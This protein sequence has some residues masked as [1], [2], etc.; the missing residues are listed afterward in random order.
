MNDNETLTLLQTRE[1]AYIP[2]GKK[3]APTR[4]WQ[5]FC[6]P[7]CRYRA[8]TENDSNTA[9]IKHLEGRIKTLESIVK[10]KEKEK[11]HGREG[12]HEAGE[13]GDCPET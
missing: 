11:E 13:H 9:K 10:S 3:F 4:Y 8:W 1:C 12:G 2:C 5:K 7:A 6:S